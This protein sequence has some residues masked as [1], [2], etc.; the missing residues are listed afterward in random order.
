[1]SVLIEKPERERAMC[2]GGARSERG[3]QE[4]D[5]G[6]LFTRRARLFRLAR[7]DIEPVRALRRSRDGNRNQLAILPGSGS[8]LPAD[9]GIERDEAGEFIRR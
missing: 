7:V 1:M 3:S 5:L 8:A 2:H 6:H 4:R 9:D